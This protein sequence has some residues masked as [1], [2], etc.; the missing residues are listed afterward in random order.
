MGLSSI[1]FG[2]DV[3]MAKE[4]KLFEVELAFDSLSIYRNIL[5][6]CLIKKLRMLIQMVNSEEVE[7]GAVV[8]LYNE[9][10]FNL[11]KTGSISFQNYLLNKMIFDENPFS[12]NAQ[13]DSI[14]IYDKVVLNDF[15]NLQSIAQISSELI[16]KRLTCILSGNE[17]SLRVIKKLPEWEDKYTTKEEK[18]EHIAKL[19]E[20]VTSYNNWNEAIAHIKSFYFSNG[21][22]IFGKYKAFMWGDGMLKGI[23]EPDEVKLSELIGYEA[24]REIIIENT[25]QLIKGKRANNVLLYGDRG[26][27]KSSTVKA[28]LNEYY[29][30]GLRMI[31][32]SKADLFDLPSIINNLKGRPQKFIIFIDDLVFADDDESYNVLKAILEGGLEGKAPNVIIYA[33][34]NRRHL[35][36]EYFYE[37]SGFNPL[38]KNSEIHAGDSIQEKL[39]LADRFGI[40]VVY[41]S[42]D[43]KK[44][45][46][47]VEGLAEMRNLKIDKEVLRA[48]AV[49]WELWYNG[50]SPRTARQFIDWL[51]GSKIIKNT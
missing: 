16:K 12:F 18:L 9:F 28:I 10:Y 19:K 21:S 40:T 33:T 37:R 35:V 34:S 13:N 31:E 51:E 32:V 7:L 20:K 27:G 23:K 8:N 43:K 36:K 5:E 47:I 6:D 24:E 2:V 29:K 30:D 44:F 3:V 1:F 17:L 14:T 15:E 49:K 48:E 46:D 45:L 26:T 22:G 4:K 39:S 25:L 11:I 38:D 41:S 42:P 50:R